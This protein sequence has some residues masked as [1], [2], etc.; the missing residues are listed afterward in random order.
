MK[1]LTFGDE[2]VRANGRRLRPARFDSRSALPL[3]AACVVASGVRETLGAL[4][5]APVTLRLFE[6]CLPSGDAWTAITRAAFAWRVRG[7]TSDGAIVLRSGDAR[8]LAWA[9]FGEGERC[10]SDTADPPLSPIEAEVLRRVVAAIAGNLQSV[11]GT[12]DRQGA[13]PEP[14]ATIAGFATYFEIQLERPAQARIGIALAREPDPPP[15]IHIRAQDLLGVAVAARV[16]GGAACVDA[17]RLADLR[18]GDD[19]VIGRGTLRARL[20]VGSRRLAAGE[21]GARDG[22]FALRVEMG[23]C[24][25]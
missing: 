16:V 14:I 5:A 19:M 12:L 25:A 8:A 21:I 20:L 24:V 1:Y 22:R 3:A 18:P 7:G 13:S 23:R 4:L 10:E 17:W 6:P 2:S 9:A 15:S 11:C